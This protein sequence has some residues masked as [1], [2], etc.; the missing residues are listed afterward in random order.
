M[1]DKKKPTHELR[2]PLT[3]ISGNAELL[4]NDDNRDNRMRHAEIIKTSAGRMASMLNSLL[5]YFRL[6]NRK[7]TILS[8]PFTLSLIADTLETEFAMQVKSRI[9]VQ[10]SAKNKRNGYLSLSSGWAMPPRRTASGWDFPS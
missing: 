6:D 10:A 9:R 1:N 3:S 5:D 8:K 2:T 4:L 7:A